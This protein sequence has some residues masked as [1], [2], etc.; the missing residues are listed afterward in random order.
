MFKYNSEGAEQIRL[1]DRMHIV[2]HA[3]QI[4]QIHPHGVAVLDF[5]K[6]LV[7]LYIIL[8]NDGKIDKFK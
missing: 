6:Y 5:K 1:G 3:D 7:I 2:L 4:V 8:D